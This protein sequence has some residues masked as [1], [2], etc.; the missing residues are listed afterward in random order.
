MSPKI[1]SVPRHVLTAL[2]KRNP[3]SPCLPASD[4][5][6]ARR[7]RQLALAR[8]RY[9]YAPRG[10][11][12]HQLGRA[13]VSSRIPLA[14][15][16]DWS[17]VGPYLP[18]LLD[19][20]TQ[21]TR[22]W[23][24]LGPQRRDARKV[25][26]D[27]HAFAR[28]RVGG[29]N[30]LTIERVRALDDLRDRLDISEDMW[31]RTLGTQARVTREIAD[32]RLFIADYRPLARALLHGS[33]R[34]L[35]FRER[36]LAAPVAVF[37]ELRSAPRPR[38]EPVLIQLDQRDDLGLRPSAF[39]PGDGAGWRLAKLYVQSADVN[40]GV[41]G[42]HLGGCHA[43]AEA[44]ALSTPRQLSPRHPVYVLLEPHLAYSLAVNRAAHTLLTRPGSVFEQV[45]SG[46][47]PL[48]RSIVA[49]AHERLASQPRTLAFDLERRGVTR[50]PLDYPFR[51]DAQLY[52]PALARFVRTYLARFYCDDA[53]VRGDGELQAWAAELASPAG[54]D[55]T[56]LLPES[57]LRT[58]EELSEVLAR[59][60]FV[61]GPLHAA[62]HFAQPELLVEPDVYPAAL[63]HPPPRHGEVV[64]A[65]R[66]SRTL[67]PR[68]VAIVQVLNNRVADYRFDRI[69]DY[70]RYRLGQMPEARD[71]IVELTRSLRAIESTIAAR[72]LAR[73]DP[74]TYLLP[75]R[76]P[77]SANI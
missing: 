22:A 69:G 59:V 63:F 43:L 32:Q 62:L 35:R 9:S 44:F 42:H 37:R 76:V 45:Y 12:G 54:G 13:P 40:L 2:R 27:D 36:Y 30:P 20:L 6:S 4:R 72:N 58:R 29:V 3:A 34:D 16:Y 41:L 67:P 1:A 53:A 49:R 46:S 55:M 33:S 47:L 70:R 66:I 10:S 19:S 61:V 18:R 77:N 14:A 21:A 28:A 25:G 51:D 68:A 56:G 57:R 23:I 8:R 26:L 73:V 24:D 39:A 48:T 15:R 75:S 50:Y 74:Y 64:S 31:E 38:L 17:W 52:G 7:R 5:G 11:V 71:A 60:L 65:S